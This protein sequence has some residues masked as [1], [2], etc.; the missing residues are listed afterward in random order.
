[1]LVAFQYVDLLLTIVVVDVDYLLY[2]NCMDS[3]W[4]K[5][6]LFDGVNDFHLGNLNLKENTFIY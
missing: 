3:L 1:M 4:Y 5:L 2:V 6:V